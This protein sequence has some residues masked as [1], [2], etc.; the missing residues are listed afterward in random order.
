MSKQAA[1]ATDAL[2]GIPGVGQIGRAATDS[3]VPE[4]PALPV[5]PKPPATDPSAQ[6]ARDMAAEEVRRRS[7][8]GRASTNPTGGTGDASM[9]NVASKY[10]LGA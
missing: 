4:M 5:P 10:L 1:L 8:Y 2:S 7:V 6:A 9:P 3:L